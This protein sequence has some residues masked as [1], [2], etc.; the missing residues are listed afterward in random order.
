MLAK[1]TIIAVQKSILNSRAAH[2]MKF[3]SNGIVL[4]KN[5][6]YFCSSNK[7]FFAGKL[8]AKSTK[9][10]KIRDKYDQLKVDNKK[11]AK[12]T[13]GWHDIKYLINFVPVTDSYLVQKDLIPILDF[14][15]K[16]TYW[17]LDDAITLEQTK[18]KIVV[19]FWLN[20]KK[21]RS[22]VVDLANECTIDSKQY[23]CTFGKYGRFYFPR[24]MN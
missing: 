6:N 12:A 2:E 17:N 23:V 10:K 4:L 24:I 7:V 11:Q 18:K 9:Q 21:I 14:A 5:S 1:D 15:C 22:T 3:S 8:R 19:N 13:S 16:R 20:N